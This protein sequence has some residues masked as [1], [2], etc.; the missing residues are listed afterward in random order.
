MQ[1]GRWS[2]RCVFLPDLW[3]I[4]ERD[5]RLRVMYLICFELSS[6]EGVFLDKNRSTALTYR[7]L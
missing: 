6:L 1:V 2:I 7:E 5:R 3:C 4:R